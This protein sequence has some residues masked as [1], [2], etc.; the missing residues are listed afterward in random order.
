M[1]HMNAINLKT[2]LYKDMKTNRF[3]DYLSPEIEMVEVTTEGI[4]CGSEGFG[5]NPMNIVDGAG[6]DWD[7]Q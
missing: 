3:A 1:D 6:S 7:W 4:L 5:I 2:I